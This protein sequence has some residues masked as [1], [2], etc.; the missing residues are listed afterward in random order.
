MRIVWDQWGGVGVSGEGLG[1]QDQG[2]GLEGT[3]QSGCVRV[4]VVCSRCVHMWCA[5]GVCAHV[6][7]SRCVHM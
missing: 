7:C 4:H 1:P 3:M 6:A 5:L 2:W